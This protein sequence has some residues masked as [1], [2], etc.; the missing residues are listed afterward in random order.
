MTLQGQVEQSSV[1][2]CASVRG[3]A[4]THISFSCSHAC[5][6]ACMQSF[7]TH[8]G[9]FVAFQQALLMSERAKPRHQAVAMQAG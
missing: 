8:H 2:V 3:C 9:S 5:V 6:H 1:Q 7:P 4:H